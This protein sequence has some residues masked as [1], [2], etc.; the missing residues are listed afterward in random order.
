LETGQWRYILGDRSFGAPHFTRLISEGPAIN[1]EVSIFS[2]VYFPAL[3]FRG[4]SLFGTVWG[5]YF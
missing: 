3:F 5:E 2:S 1:C 4:F